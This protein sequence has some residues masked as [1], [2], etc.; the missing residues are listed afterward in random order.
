MNTAGVSEAP[1]QAIVPHS[2][3]I[4][5]SKQELRLKGISDVAGTRSP[6]R[7]VER[8][9]VYESWSWRPAPAQVASAVDQPHILI[10]VPPQE[11]RGGQVHGAGHSDGREHFTRDLCIWLGLH[12]GREQGLHPA[13][14]AHPPKTK[15]GFTPGGKGSLAAQDPENVA[16]EDAGASTWRPGQSPTD[17]AAD[18]SG[19]SVP[20]MSCGARPQPPVISWTAAY[21]R[22]SLSNT[23]GWLVAVPDVPEE[24]VEPVAVLRDR[25]RMKY[26]IRAARIAKTRMIQSQEAPLPS[27]SPG[28]AAGRAPSTAAPTCPPAAG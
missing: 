18:I 20:A 23:L 15:A 28:T 3:P 22:L 25:P 21:L 9:P 8:D 27:G 6:V 16:R 14:L 17:P 7:A 19:R 26:Q 11:R 24:P 4:P 5:A 1:G 13:D 2:S 10:N 12:P